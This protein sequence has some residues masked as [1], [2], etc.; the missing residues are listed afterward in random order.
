MQALQ[1]AH[2][3]ERLDEAR[4]MSRPNHQFRFVEARM[5][6][7]PALTKDIRYIAAYP[8]KDGRLMVVLAQGMDKF[9]LKKWEGILRA[10]HV[11]PVHDMGATL[12]AAKTQENFQEQGKFTYCRS[13]PAI[14]LPVPVIQPKIAPKPIQPPKTNYD[15]PAYIMARQACQKMQKCIEEREKFNSIV[16]DFD[17][18]IDKMYPAVPRKTWEQSCQQARR[19]AGTAALQYVDKLRHAGLLTN[20]N[21]IPPSLRNARP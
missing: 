5:A 1:T 4:S 7:V 19:D 15:T 6:S 17:V 11:S 20:E 18:D 3:R 12:S 13:T 9:T 16:L 10:R 2:I 8:S 21:I 14:V